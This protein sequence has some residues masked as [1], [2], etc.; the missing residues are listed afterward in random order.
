M[1][2]RQWLIKSSTTNDRQSVL[3]F[4][5]DL[6]RCSFG[7]RSVRVQL[8]GFAARHEPVDEGDLLGCVRNDLLG[9]L[10]GLG[11]FIRHGSATALTNSAVEQQTLKPYARGLRLQS[12]CPQPPPAMR[13][14]RS[15]SNEAL[16]VDM[17]IAEEI[18]NEGPRGLSRI[19]RLD[20]VTARCT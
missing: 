20:G 1:W 19:P 12:V 7:K 8:R 15:W 2:M 11:F 10:R 17:S 6:V 9:R 16:I 14:S 13:Q 5:D 3:R 4:A 18:I